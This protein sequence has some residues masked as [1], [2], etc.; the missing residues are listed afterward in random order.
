LLAGKEDPGKFSNCK[1]VLRMANANKKD[2]TA[3]TK[4]QARLVIRNIGLLLSGDLQKP[5][6]DADTV[7]AVDG[8]ITAVGKEND[9]DA[10]G[11]TLIIDAKGTTLAPGLI[12][13][14][15]HPVAGDW[16]P[17]QNQI[18]W[19]DSYL[20]GGV[21][22]MISAGE[23]HTPGRPKDV[24]G[25]KAMAIFAQ[26]AFSHFRPGG[27]RIHAGAPVIEHGMVEE[28]FKDL[29]AAGVTMLG[30]VGLGSVKDG[31]TAREMVGW[32]RKFG[33]QSTIHTGGPSIPGSSL[34]DKDIVL[35]ADADVIGHINGGHTALPDDQIVTL[36]EKSPRALEMVHNGNERA[37][38]LALR[39]AKELKQLDRVILG[40]DSPAGSGVQPLGILRM[41]SMLSSL[42][43]IPVEIAVCFATGNTAKI[44]NLDC[45]LVAVG[46]AATFVVIDRAQH[47]A[48][49][50][51]LESI[52]LGDLPGIG[53]V[54]I[55]GL[56][57]A[58]R[59]RNT[60]PATSAPEVVKH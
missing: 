11:A 52:Q 34:I 38:L 29:A 1:E 49:T 46:R 33:I 56:V 9:V 19:I 22:T 40:T 8:K 47:S 42:G 43:Q 7:I 26:R 6:L 58:Q 35:A 12:D 44:R 15:V 16:T 48:G 39:T 54:I 32:A 4:P 45:G 3:Q 23:V 25:L 36:C 55:D 51:V 57:S 60:P 31:A 24:V 53:M 21:T 14:H 10:E 2:E 5:I 41:I 13:S 18:G 28:D 30:E 50:T 17:R 27:V 37:A 20:H 59:S